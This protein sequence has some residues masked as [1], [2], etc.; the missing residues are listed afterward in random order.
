MQNI[1]DEDPTH[2]V[3]V[4]S[5]FKPMLKIIEA[6]LDKLG[7]SHVKITGDVNTQ[8]RH[9]HITAF[10]HD[11]KCRVFLSSDAGAYGVNLNRGSHLICYDLPWSAGVLQQ[12][13]SRIDRTSSSFSSIMV[14]Y[15][16]GQGTI[17]ERMMRQLKDKLAVA[18]AF[19]DGD[20]DLQ[21]G[22][23]PLDFESLKDFL[24][25]S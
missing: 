18:G 12:R 9:R 13:I 25:A 17:E 1:L 7:I 14:I 11:P 15:L 3:V 22:S 10:N 16:Y 23:L 8:T 2:K 5:Y 6:A 20:Y 4:F 21:T 24:L 19:L